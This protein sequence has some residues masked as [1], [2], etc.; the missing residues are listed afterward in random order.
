MHIFFL[1]GSLI[2]GA[3]V[4]T[5]MRR[6]SSEGGISIGG[7][8]GGLTFILLFSISSAI[9]LSEGTHAVLHFFLTFPTIND[10]SKLIFFSQKHLIKWRMISL[11]KD[12]FDIVGII[13]VPIL[14]L[15][16]LFCSW[17]LWELYFLLLFNHSWSCIVLKGLNENF[18]HILEQFMNEGGFSYSSM[19]LTH[20]IALMQIQEFP[21]TRY[22][23]FHPIF[24]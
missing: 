20:T 18:V 21:S 9:Q 19:T 5:K 8:H 3:L 2:L 7:C 23:N 10:Q 15:F 17:W 6:L 16:Y 4:K 11:G 14:V 1:S 12:Q 22:K 13:L 24:V